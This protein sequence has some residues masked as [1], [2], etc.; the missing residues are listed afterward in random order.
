MRRLLFDAGADFDA[1]MLLCESDITSKN[2][3]KRIRYLENFELVKKRCIEVEEKDAIRNWQ[4]PITGELIMQTFGIPPSKQV[5]LI[6]DA[7]REAILD[8]AIPNDYA[9]AHQYMLEKAKE[10]HLLPIT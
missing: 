6:K 4:P 1:L 10:Y 2:R 5:G 9:S 7:I 8:G 3:Q